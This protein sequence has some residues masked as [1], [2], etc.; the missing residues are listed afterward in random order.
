VRTLII[1][2]LHLGNRHARDVLRLGAPRER[3]LRAVDGV[4]R[5]V[6]LG[7]TVEL[8]TRNPRHSMAVAEPVLRDLGRRLGRDREVIVIAG[9]HDAPLVRRWAL[10]RGRRL[11]IDERVAPSVT[12]ALGRITAWLAPARV[13]VHYPGAWLEDRVWVTHGHYLDRH[14]VPESAFGLPRGRLRTTGGSGAA[15]PFDY[16]RARRGRRGSRSPQRLLS[17][18]A[19][20]PL[21]T[22]LE[23]SAELLRSAAVPQLPI[24]LQR[25]RLTSLTAA[26][27]DVQMRHAALAA[28]GYVVKR[29]GVD[30]DWV[31]FGH[32]HRTGPLD[33]EAWP[34]SDPRLLNCGSWVFEPLLVD[35]ASAPHPYWPGGAVVLE[36]GHPPRAVSLLD[37][38]GP[39]QLLVGAGVATRAG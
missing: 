6:L 5:L 26:V 27:I 4:D 3:L 16:E 39:E 8:M 38:L 24:M 36:S 25:A 34:D 31:V 18:L 19:A 9:N 12:R 17:R 28:M 22:T 33:G 10:D 32:V 30:A 15:S 29:L 37:D 23:L 21:A 11:G 14:L 1:S 20:R 13:S 35:R 2:D 7:D